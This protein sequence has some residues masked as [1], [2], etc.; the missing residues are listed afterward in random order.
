VTA[1]SAVKVV[2]FGLAKLPAAAPAA[3]DATV[4]AALTH[5]GTVLGTSRASLGSGGSG[6]RSRRASRAP[7]PPGRGLRRSVSVPQQGFAPV[8]HHDRVTATDAVQVSTETGLQF[9]GSD[10]GRGSHVVIMPTRRDRTSRRVSDRPASPS[11]GTASAPCA[12][13]DPGR[14]ERHLTQNENTGGAVGWCLEVH[15]LGS[16]MLGPESNVYLR[17]PLSIACGNVRLPSSFT[18]IALTHFCL[19]HPAGPIHNLPHPA[20]G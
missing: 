19:C 11:A 9:P 16:G 17:K 3:G 18:S 2:D 8:R 13:P 12:E 10:D 14:D 5:A 4:S 15:D 1:G 20:E 7:P 6:R